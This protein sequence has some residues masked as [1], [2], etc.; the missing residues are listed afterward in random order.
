MPNSP[1]LVCQRPQVEEF[2]D[3][4]VV[5]LANALLP[6]PPA[7]AAHEPRFPL[8]VGYCHS[9]HAVQLLHLVPPEQLFSDYC[10]ESSFSDAF[11][12]HARSYA[13]HLTQRLGLGKH[14][15]VVEVASNDGYLLQNFVAAAVPCLGVEPAR[16]IAA[17][18]NARGIPTLVRFFDPE[19]A[20]LVAQ[21]HGRAD[22]IIGN[23]VLAHAPALVPFLAAAREL[24]QPQ[25]LAVFE[26]PW[27]R[28]LVQQLEFD[29]IYHEH[30]FY[31]SLLALQN[32]ARLAGLELHDVQLQPV[33][34]G[35]LRIFLQHPG[36]RPVTAEVPRVLELEQGSGLDRPEVYRTMGR[37]VRALR[38]AL[39]SML[40]GFKQ[41]HKRIAAYGASAKGSTLLNYCGIGKETIDYIVDRS[42]VKQG[43]FAPGVHLP[44]FG[45]E[46]LLQDRPDYT[47]LLA[48]NFA[49]E[50]RRQQQAY[51]QRGGRFL[52]PVPEP[53]VLE[54]AVTIREAHA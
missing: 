23:N 10:Y 37:R 25:G 48:W 22:V 42:T 5:P 53:R 16:N 33:H 8:R 17:K 29:T 38:L 32:A 2:L 19:T 20:Q 49:D 27:L 1:C 11:L 52:H 26:F 3:L 21:Q 34:G 44:I 45:V 30:V 40:S 12:A 24:L 18:A 39:R 50:I 43:R 41:Q 35:S 14:S 54:P 7:D 9:C 15:F 51:E 13:E 6:A 4:G 28:A 36:A 46:R 47:L 31:L